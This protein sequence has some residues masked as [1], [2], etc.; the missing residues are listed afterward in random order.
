MLVSGTVLAGVAY[1][2]VGQARGLAMLLLALL[3][4]GLGA[5]TQQ[6]LASSMISDVYEDGGWI[7]QALSKYNFS[8]DLGARIG[9]AD[10]K[11]H[12]VANRCRRVF[13]TDRVDGDAA[14]ALLN[15]ACAQGRSRTV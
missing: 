8:G 4:G 2:L 11:Q 5:S 14:G 9:I 6:P 13:A 3:L 12:G 1:L 7:K 10:G 15:G